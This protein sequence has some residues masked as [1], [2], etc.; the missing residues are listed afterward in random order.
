[1]IEKLKIESTYILAFGYFKLGYLMSN[2][3]LVE[4]ERIENKTK[5]KPVIG[6]IWGTIWGQFDITI[7]VDK[8]HKIDQPY[9][10]RKILF[11]VQ[12]IFETIGFTTPVIF[13]PKLILQQTWF[14]KFKWDD[15][16]PVDLS[17]QLNNWIKGIVLLSKIEIHLRLNADSKNENRVTLH[18]CSKVAYFLMVRRLGS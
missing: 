2:V 7:K 14:L 6:L 17:R 8:K 4:N 11:G 10:K 13:I 9:I 15:E 18:R 12:K 1:M 3:S 16:L 5:I